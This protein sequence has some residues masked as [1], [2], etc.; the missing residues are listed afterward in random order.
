MN[1]KA[2]A[3]VTLLLTLGLV[4]DIL[5]V[6]TVLH[7][8]GWAFSFTVTIKQVIGVIIVIRLINIVSSPGSKQ[9]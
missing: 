6:G 1:I 5:L 7:I 4:V 2:I 9:P 8:L 3:V